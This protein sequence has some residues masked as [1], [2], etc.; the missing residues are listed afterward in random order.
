MTTMKTLPQPALQA[1]FEKNRFL[2]V[3]ALLAALM[4]TS[5]G[6]AKIAVPLYALQL[7]ASASQLGL[8]AAGAMSGGLIMSIPVGFLV[9]YYGPGKLFVIGSSLAGITYLILPSVQ[10]IGFL[11]GCVTAI[12]FFMPLRFVSLNT[13][14]F[15]QIQ[16]L[17]AEKAGWYRGTHMSGMFLIG[18]GVAIALISALGYTGVWWVVAASFAITIFI[19]PV[20]FK[21][22]GKLTGAAE[23]PSLAGIF[24]GLK[25]L[26][27]N[28]KLRWVCAIDFFLSAVSIYRDTFIVVIAIKNMHLST[29]SVSM[30][31]TSSGCAFIFSL[32]F[33]GSIVHRIGAHKSYFWGLGM[34]I[35]ALLLLGLA[36]QA[37][38]LWPGVILLGLGIGLL[39]VVTLTQ[40]AHISFSLGQGKVSGVAMQVPPLGALLGGAL[41]GIIGQYM[42]LQNVFFIFSLVFLTLFFVVWKTNSEK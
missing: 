16:S 13:V 35:I 15:R 34:A 12:S 33:A 37:F 42:G 8:I 23:R 21:R 5:V 31:V 10:S 3:F 36:T 32:F 4:G 19:C 39:Q 6:I 26:S 1:W 28:Q 24:G 41:G 38:W 2:L 40:I 22:Y 14:F 11:L 20:V 30:L 18:P 9:D 25:L 17:G 29:A 7:G 27:G